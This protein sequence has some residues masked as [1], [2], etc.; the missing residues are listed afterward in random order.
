LC[1]GAVAGLVAATPSSG[2]I[3]P[4]AGIVCGIVAAATCNYATKLKFVVAIDDSMDIFAVH[5]LAGA[6]GLLING[7]FGVNY[8]PALDGLTLGN[9]AIPGGWF[10]RHWIQLLYQIAYIGATSSYSFV[11][12]AIILYLMNLVPWLRLRVSRD[13]EREG[14]DGAE[15]GEFAFD[16][17]E[18]RRDYDSWHAPDPDLIEG[19]VREGLEQ[20]QEELVNASASS[21]TTRYSS[22]NEKPSGVGEGKV[23]PPVMGGGE[24]EIE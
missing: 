1:S 14:I 22:D 21:D 4:H 5:G 12:T 10:N 20:Q 15:L 6:I 3:N 8:V 19:R 7:F 13:G 18:V 11:M 9:A 2:F 24:T 16:F 23:L 17:V